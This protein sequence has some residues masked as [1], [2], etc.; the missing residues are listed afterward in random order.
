MRHGLATRW[1]SMC[2]QKPPFY[3]KHV[4]FDGWLVRL[5]EA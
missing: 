3:V 2:S 1:E 4:G 5:N